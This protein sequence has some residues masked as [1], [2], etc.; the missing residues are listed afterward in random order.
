CFYAALAALA[1]PRHALNVH[2]GG[3]VSAFAALPKSKLVRVY[4]LRG[5][6]CNTKKG[7][8]MAEFE[9][10]FKMINVN[11]KP[12][13][14]RRAI[15]QGE[16][17]VTSKTYE[18]IKTKTL[19]KGDAVALAEVAGIMAAKNVS[20]Q[21]PLCHPINLDEVSILTQFDDNE[22]TITVYCIVVACAKTGVE[23]EAL[24]GVN[25][26]LLTLYDLAKNVDPIISL[27]NIRL[28]IKEGGKQGLWLH[29]LGIPQAFE[30][31]IQ[32]KQSL[33][34]NNIT[35]SLLTVSDRASQGIYEDKSGQVLLNYLKDQGATI[36]SQHLL[37]D[38]EA[39]IVNTIT[40][41]VRAQKPDIF[42]VTGGTGLGPKDVTPEAISAICDKLVP[43]IGEHL[44]LEGK[45][46]TKRAILSRSLAGILEQT[47]ILSLPGNPA[48]VEEG[49]LLLK[50]ILPHAIKIIKGQ[51]CENV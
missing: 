6:D 32:S 27:H 20:S 14:N 46:F 19:P 41:T 33:A 10:I 29:P 37:P 16:I 26:A 47:L 42:I 21:I 51:N 48:A 9:P 49:L 35:V 4:S 22:N 1:H 5:L 15:A 39:L 45:S 38:N 30:T 18:L 25:G 43:G 7:H 23:M 40:E 2:S 50:E 28:L 13:T 12:F 3:G 11:S 36:K 24:A 17:K 8:E 34:F 44:R 31:Q